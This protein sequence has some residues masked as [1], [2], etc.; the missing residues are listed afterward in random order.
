MTRRAREPKLK[1]CP[2]CGE[3]EPTAE[4]GE[5]GDYV[6]C[7]KCGAQGPGSTDEYD[8]G[9]TEAIAEWNRVASMRQL[10]EDLVL[11]HKENQTSETNRMVRALVLVVGRARA[12]LGRTK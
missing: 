3:Q 11:A 8:G 9:V 2:F 7:W 6:W 10:L 1:P 5:G 4:E 12:A